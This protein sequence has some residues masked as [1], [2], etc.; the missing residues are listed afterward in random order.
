MIYWIFTWSGSSVVEFVEQDEDVITDELARAAD[1]KDEN[2]E[3]K[4]KVFLGAPLPLTEKAAPPL[5]H[6]CA[7]SESGRR[8][9]ALSNAEL[10]SNL[11]SWE[12]ETGA[13][14]PITSESL[15]RH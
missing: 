9:A 12:D 1:G 8:P 5:P 14:A 4:R 2:G 10:S 7:S 13:T 3:L 6:P 15:K 11:T